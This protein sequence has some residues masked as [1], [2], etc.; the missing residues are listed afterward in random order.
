MGTRQPHGG[1]RWCGLILQAGVILILLSAA[2]ANAQV[3]VESA[4]GSQ[5]MK[6]G[7]LVQGRYETTD[8]ADGS[9]R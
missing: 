8:L 4:D 3:K 2:T 1:A 5:S 7:F 9:D 6:F